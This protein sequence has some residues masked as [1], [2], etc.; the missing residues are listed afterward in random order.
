M[1]KTLSLL[2]LR[3]GR[4]LVQTD[5]SVAQLDKEVGTGQRQA[6]PPKGRVTAT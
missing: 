1:W 4:K 6:H 3:V 2:A 5:H